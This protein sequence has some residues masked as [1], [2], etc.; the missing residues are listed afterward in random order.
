VA[1][2]YNLGVGFKGFRRSVA[3]LYFQCRGTP[4]T[5][6]CTPNDAGG[7]QTRPPG[8]PHSPSLGMRE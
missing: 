8:K 6:R 2:V 1:N 4:L 3:G 5:A 7:F